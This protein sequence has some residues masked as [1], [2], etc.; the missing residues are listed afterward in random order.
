MRLVPG[1]RWLGL[2]RYPMSSLSPRVL[3]WCRS[4][5]RSPLAG[6]CG[7]Y[8]AVGSPASGLLQEGLG[9][10]L[11][12]LAL[13]GAAAYA[14]AQEA[15]PAPAVTLSKW[16]GAVNVPDPVA[17]A[18]DPQGRVYVATTARRRVADLDIR[19]H[20]EWADDDLGLTS[21][22][23]KEAFFRAALAPGR[24]RAP[25]GDLGD[26]NKDGSVD[27]QDLTVQT[28]RIYQLRDTDGDG[29]ADRG[30][31]FAEGFN[32]VVTG[33]A[34][35]VL[36][37]DGWVWATIA[38]DLWRFKDTDDDGVADIRE[39]VV[40]GFGNHISYGGHDMHGL[41]VG[42]DGRIYW[43]IGDKGVNVT[44][45]EGRRF[46]FP[47][48]GCVL[49]VEPDGTGFE[50]FARGLRNPQEP[51]FD[52][53]GDWIVVD[54]DADQPGERER[55]VH[56]LEGSDSGWRFNHQLMATESTWMK[57]GLWQTP[58]AGQPAYVLPPLAYY[59]DGPGGFKRN[60]GAA[61]GVDWRDTYF[62]S[63]FPSGK[64][65]GF[66][67]E[68]DGATFRQVDA[69]VLHEGIM[70]VGM[71]WHP[72]GSL[73]MV[74]WLEGWIVKGKGAVWRIDTA[75][76]PSP[77]RTETRALLDA[78]FGGRSEAELLTLLGQ[79]DQRVRLGAQLELARRGQGEALLGVARDAAAARL[80]RVHALWGYGQLTRRDRAPVEPL[81]PLLEDA[82]GEIRAQAVKILGDSPSAARA[83]GRLLPRLSDPE[84]RVRL[85]AAIAAGKLRVREAVPALFALAAAEW[86]KPHLR[87][88]AITGLSGAAT[89]EE[90]AERNADTGVATRLAAV[91]ALRRQESPLLARFLDDA[92]PVVAAEAA[93]AIHDANVR[94]AWPALAKSL[95]RG[96]ADVAA[97]RR[98]VNAN[99]LLGTVEAAARLLAH[100]L[101]AR[102]PAESRAEALE[103]LVSWPKPPRADRVDGQSRQIKTVPVGAVLQP[104]IDALLAVDQLELRVAAVRLMIAHGLRADETRIAAIVADQQAPGEL[105]A[106]ALRLLASGDGRRSLA[107]RG[108]LDAGLASDAPP[109]LHGAGLESLLPDEPERL[110]AEARAVL[111]GRTLPE[112]Q[113]VYR[114]LAQAAHP[115]ADALLAEQAAGLATGAVDAALRLDLLEALRAR[116]GVNPALKAAA[117][118]YAASPAGRAEE[119]LLSGGDQVRGRAIVTSNLAANCVSCHAVTA[120]GSEVGPNLS[121]VGRQHT[122]AYLLRSLVDPAAEIAAGFGVVVVT[123]KDETVVSGTLTLATPTDIQV[124]LFDG[125]SRSI[126]RAQIASQTDPVSVMPTMRGVLSPQEIRDVVAYLSSLG[127]ERRRSQGSSE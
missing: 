20:L 29:V 43:S 111:G 120:S 83:G 44:S 55:L 67:L 102:A 73:L 24:M 18:I 71:S 47:H 91:V 35:G 88:A 62:L 79:V 81:F 39:K 90:L 32:S 41:V 70:G 22:A 28:E 76:A 110:V 45:R 14:V 51:A 123:L 17:C 116:G 122:P 94:A 75:G 27:W 112:R 80:A 87:H 2:F 12:F 125:T 34:A 78:G 46:Y 1:L 59:S 7:C 53:F 86:E 108:A 54:N 6:D 92:E 60:P 37:H 3:N 13:S 85:Q 106:Q 63:E 9:L 40:T 114:L 95:E 69:R 26:H 64:L 105:R 115:A 58:F 11:A 121:T 8:D 25:R 74:D 52:D 61:L 23:E 97:R 103:C 84:P 99:L 77:A 57:E 38:P 104:G 113:Q 96:P 117:A 126:P 66:R 30:T 10:L 19:Q 98:A 127:R 15:P 49:R 109:A 36:W 100:A 21:I 33:I 48:D 124:R 42:P 4:V 72:D 68:R 31:V 101:D 89:A 56:I 65:R 50:V 107:W 119:E 82:D 16:S 93:R 118:A 5:C